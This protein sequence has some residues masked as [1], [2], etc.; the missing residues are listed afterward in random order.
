[1]PFAVVATNLERH[2]HNDSSCPGQHLLF[3]TP[4]LSLSRPVCP[5]TPR[6]RYTCS[7]RRVLAPPPPPHSLLRNP[8]Y[9]FPISP[10]ARNFQ[11]NVFCPGPLH[12]TKKHHTSCFPR[13]GPHHHCYTATQWHL[14]HDVFLPPGLP[15]RSSAP[16]HWHAV[17]SPSSLLYAT[18]PPSSLYHSPTTTTQ[19]TRCVHALPRLFTTSVIPL[20]CPIS[21]TIPGDGTI[22][23]C[24]VLVL[25][26]NHTQWDGLCL[27]F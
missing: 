20:Y 26:C 7:T 13:S 12:L 25:L 4:R 9:Q 27:S 11:S 6:H 15:S 18:C 16:Q 17:L 2:R 21:L 8:I 24:R 3:F 22:P 19:G 1:M 5:S 14:Q 10:L 23:T